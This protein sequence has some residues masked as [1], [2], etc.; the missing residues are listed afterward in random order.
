MT[1]YFFD[2]S[3]L[4]KLYLREPGS[5]AAARL[6][7]GWQTTP[8]FASALAR[9]EARAAFQ[10]LSRAGSIP[11]AAAAEIIDAL[12]RDLD[13]AFQVQPMGSDV[14]EIASLLVIRRPLRAADAIHL[15]SC[16]VL[17]APEGL[18]IFVCSDKRLLRAARDEGLE[19][20]DP[21]APAGA[22]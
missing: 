10:A 6:A 20:L 9:V 7:R 17:K 2:T 18:P 5:D 8:V 22:A 12:D 4:V 13:Q 21:A 11:S 1:G 19:T 3:A 16:I 15:A 14:V